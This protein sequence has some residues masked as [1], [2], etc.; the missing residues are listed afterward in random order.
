M[1]NNH[2]QILS[3]KR[4]SNLPLFLFDNYFGTKSFRTGINN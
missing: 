4:G 3:R 1:K 2:S